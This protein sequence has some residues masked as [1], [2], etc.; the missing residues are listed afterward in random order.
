MTWR[1]YYK[2][3]S[4]H[5]SWLRRDNRGS[6]AYAWRWTVRKQR[7]EWF[8]MEE[9]VHIFSFYQ[10]KRLAHIHVLVEGGDVPVPWFL[11]CP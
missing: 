9:L 1:A 7:A 10:K 8:T 3:G 6:D 11:M 5:K 2:N 4:H